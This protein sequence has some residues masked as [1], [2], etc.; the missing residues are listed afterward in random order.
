MGMPRIQTPKDPLLTHVGCQAMFR[1]EV[2]L[3]EAW[4]WELF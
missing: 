1:Q 3:Q 2:V 4:A